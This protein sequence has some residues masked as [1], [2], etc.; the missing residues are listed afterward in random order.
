MK[1]YLGSYIPNLSNHTAPLRQLLHKES[2]FQWHHKH[3]TAFD[4][5]K[6]L[7]RNANTLTYFDPEQPAIIQVDASQY[8]LG[9]ALLQNNKI[10]A[11]ASKSLTDTEKR[12]ANIERKMLAC[13]LGAER[14][15]TYVYGKP[16]TIESDHRP[17]ETISAKHLTSAPARLQRML[18][19]LQRYSYT[20]KC[21]P[22]K[23]MNLADSLSRLPSTRP[24]REI[25]LDMK[26]CFI[27]FSEARQQQL[28][29]ETA[30]DQVLD[31]LKKHIYEGFPPTFH[32][33]PLDLRSYWSIR[34]ELSMENSTIL[35]GEQALIP[36]TLQKTIL[37]NLHEGYQG[38]T[39]SQ[40]R[41]KRPKSPKTMDNLIT[42]CP[43]C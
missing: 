9:A 28:K 3:Q 41:A 36:K 4:T 22:G 29:E 33:M 5:L 17:L 2:E 34:D 42:T 39:R 30:K 26:V 7:V 37:D 40:Q 32:D 6:A 27:L 23:E 19:R 13:V 16:F 10:I 14:F 11:Y 12:Y 35:K 31:L 18:L 20:I 43:I 21:R 38:I 25:Q 1:T 15:H 8:A 24:A